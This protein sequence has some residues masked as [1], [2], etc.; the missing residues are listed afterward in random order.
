M[1]KDTKILI[2]GARGFIGSALGHYLS[3]QGFTNVMG[4]DGTRQGLD[5]GNDAELGWIF[6]ESFDVVFHFA[7]RLPTKENC[8][9]YPAGLMYENVFVTSKVLEE[10]RLNGCKKFITMWDSSCYPEATPIPYKE[11]DLWRGEPHW[12]KRY[13]GNSAKVMMEMT[14]AF[15]TQFPQMTC[16]NLISPEVYGPNSGF[17]PRKNKTIESVITNIRA[18][19]DHN[20][21]LNIKGASKTTRDFIYI[22]DAVEALHNAM[23]YAEESGVYNISEGLDY[24]LKE[25]HEIVAEYA[26]FEKNIFWEEKEQDIQLRSCLNI[27]L[28]KEK[29]LWSPK[30]DIKKG[31]K[32]TL[33][34][35]DSNLSTKYV[36]EDSIIE[37]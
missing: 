20:I 35:H 9:E 30:V 29:L 17:N 24:S 27:G 2:T 16:I 3:S 5:L 28:A 31:L 8:L 19:Q 6:D 4:L 15:A 23:V 10:A 14:M 33:D 18:S 7:T 11:E 36:L 26:G 13:Y 22:Y 12:T 21:D 25:L 1:N 34:Y 32:L 37:R